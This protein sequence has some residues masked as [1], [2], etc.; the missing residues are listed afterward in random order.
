LNIVV[1]K[2][3]LGAIKAVE[4]ASGKIEI[5]EKQNPKL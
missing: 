3:S 1:D 5:K 2:A 4:K